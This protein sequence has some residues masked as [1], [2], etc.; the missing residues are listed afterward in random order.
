MIVGSFNFPIVLSFLSQ[1]KPSK[2]VQK[3]VKRGCGAMMRIHRHEEHK[4]II[5]QLRQE[6]NHPLTTSTGMTR[7]WK[8]HNKIGEGTRRIMKDMMENNSTTTQMY[9]YL[10]GIA[11]GASMLPYTRTYFQSVKQSI[12]IEENTDDIKKTLRLFVEMQKSSKDFFY[13]VDVGKDDKIKNVFWSHAW[14]RLSYKHF[15][16]VVTFDT[17]Y[18]TNIY[19]MPFAPFVG[20]NNHFQTI[21]FGCALVIKESEDA[22]KW[23]FSTFLKAVEDKHPVGILTGLL[24]TYP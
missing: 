22:F 20:V 7:N 5:T 21:I 12:R 18:Q 16:D 24:S 23:L 6:H 9:G 11:G 17:T 1:G 13:A 14:S 2:G 10:A 4:W 19:G 3:S 15:G 8:S